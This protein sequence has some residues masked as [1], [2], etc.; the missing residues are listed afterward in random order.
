MYQTTSVHTVHTLVAY[1]STS[2]YGICQ[3]F[4]DFYEN[5]ITCNLKI[6]LG[7]LNVSS[8]FYTTGLIKDLHILKKGRV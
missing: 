8:A 1:V 7:I 4:E 3:V 2:I 6:I 5:S